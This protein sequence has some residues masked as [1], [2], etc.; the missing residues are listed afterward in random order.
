MTFQSYLYYYPPILSP[1]PETRAYCIYI[2]TYI[3]YTLIFKDHILLMGWDA[4]T[5]LSA[6]DGVTVTTMVFHDCNP[7]APVLV[8]DFNGDGWNDVV[9]MCQDK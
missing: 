1:P 7:V 2:L 4:L 9:L 8:E 3:F 5:L 6:E